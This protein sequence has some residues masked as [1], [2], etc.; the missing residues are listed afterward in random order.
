M[1]EKSDL[2]QKKKLSLENEL[3]RIEDALEDISKRI[4]MVDTQLNLK[5]QRLYGLQQEL[6]ALLEKMKNAGDKESQLAQ[7][8]QLIR[9]RLKELSSEKRATADQLDNVRR[10]LRSLD[11]EE[12]RIKYRIQTYEGYT[13]SVRAIFAKKPRHHLMVFTM[14]LEI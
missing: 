6:G 13:R 14:W 2:I 1:K 11:E 7:E 12:S 3:S 4:S 10:M 8:L 9:E 5:S